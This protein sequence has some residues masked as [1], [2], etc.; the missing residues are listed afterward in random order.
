MPPPDR[1]DGQATS[2]IILVTV[3]TPIPNCFEISRLHSLLSLEQRRL[4]TD[5]ALPYASN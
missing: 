3:L 4:P 5:S 2:A 1:D